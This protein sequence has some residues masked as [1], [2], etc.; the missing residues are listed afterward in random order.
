MPA[1]EHQPFATVII[2]NFHKEQKNNGEYLCWKQVDGWAPHTDRILRGW[3]HWGVSVKELLE[4]F[5]DLTRTNLR[6]QWR[7][8]ES[9]SAEQQTGTGL[10]TARNVHVPQPVSI[11]GRRFRAAHD[12]LGTRAQRPVYK[13]QIG[14]SLINTR[15]T[16]YV[17]LPMGIGGIYRCKING[18]LAIGELERMYQFVEWAPAHQGSLARCCRR[19]SLAFFGVSLHRSSG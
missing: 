3:G 14:S 11:L 8:Q 1:H 12:F 18:R 5:P 10:Q 15:L 9:E 16:E 17:R 19:Y 13:S 7:R 2:P 4:M 6:A